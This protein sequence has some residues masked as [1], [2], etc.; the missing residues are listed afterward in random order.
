MWL[1]FQLISLGCWPFEMLSIPFLLPTIDLLQ[2]SKVILN[3]HINPEKKI[4]NY[5]DS[6]KV[7]VE[8]NQFAEI[9]KQITA[10]LGG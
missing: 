9:Q 1:L 4:K 7:V 6:K 8:N 3:L 10:P 2:L 5:P